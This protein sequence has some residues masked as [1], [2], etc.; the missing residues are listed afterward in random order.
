MP[1][2]DRRPQ[3]CG[4]VE[5]L[6]YDHSIESFETITLYQ[7]YFPLLA[8]SILL[9][10]SVLNANRTSIQILRSPQHNNGILLNSSY[11]KVDH[12]WKY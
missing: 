12:E 4:V 2:A 1:Q 9:E 8:Q 10:A 7:F 6:V 5:M 11:S 3:S